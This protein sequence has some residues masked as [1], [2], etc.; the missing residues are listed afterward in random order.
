MP[1]KSYL[2]IILSGIVFLLGFL[3]AKH[4]EEATKVGELQFNGKSLRIGMSKEEVRREVGNLIKS[5]T[6]KQIYFQ[7]KPFGIMAKV[8]CYFSYGEDFLCTI[9][10]SFSSEVYSPAEFRDKLESVLNRLIEMYGKPTEQRGS[11]GMPEVAWYRG[12]QGSWKEMKMNLPTYLSWKLENGNE[13]E[14][15]YRDLIGPEYTLRFTG[16]PPD[17]LWK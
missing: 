13:I 3:I 9:L 7:A 4:T 16:R 1:K 11:F 8:R 15:W 12:A 6:E 14:Y 10:C 17:Y 5:E 2:L